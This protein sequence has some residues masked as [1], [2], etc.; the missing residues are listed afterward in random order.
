MALALRRHCR[1]RRRRLA[2]LPAD[3][4]PHHRGGPHTTWLHLA[5]HRLCDA[6]GAGQAVQ[7]HTTPSHT[8][9]RKH[10]PHGA[11]AALL[12]RLHSRAVHR[13]IHHRVHPAPGRGR[14]VQEGSAALGRRRNRNGPHPCAARGRHHPGCSRARDPDRIARPA[15][16]RSHSA[17]RDITRA[18]ARERGSN[19]AA[20]RI[21]SARRRLQSTRGRSARSSSSSSRRSSGGHGPPS[22]ASAGGSP[23]SSRSSA[24][25]CSR[26]CS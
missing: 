19:Q 17:R 26:P 3:P 1:A 23:S 6:H 18:P 9:R 20:V 4:P 22:S 13:R 12:T 8:R 24:T 11:L 2:A 7:R 5:D 16:A 21:E 10:H 15:T 14:T 25:S